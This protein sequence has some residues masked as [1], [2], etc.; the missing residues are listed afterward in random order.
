[1]NELG[2]R[3][4]LRKELYAPYYV[5][6]FAIH[7]FN[8]MNQKKKIYWEGGEVPSLRLHIIFVAPPGYMKSYYLKQM[9]GGDHAL[10]RTYVED[11]NENGINMIY[12]QNLNESGLVGTWMK[13]GEHMV[14]KHGLAERHA[15]SFVLVDEFKGITD[16]LRSNGQMDTQ[17]LAAL[18][19]GHIAK[20]MAG[21]TI[22]YDTNFTMWGGVQP[23]RYELEGGMG[24][25]MLFLVNN[26]DDKLKRELRRAQFEAKN[27]RSDDLG[28]KLFHREIDKW[29]ES[30]EII[31]SVEFDESIIDLYDKYDVEPYDTSYFDR[32]ILGYHLATMGPERQML[33]DVKDSYLRELIDREV[34]WRKQ[35][36]MGPDLIQIQ[37]VI[38]TF[39]VQ[40]GNVCAIKRQTYIEQCA[41]ISISATKALS[42]LE[43]LQHYGLVIVSGQNITMEI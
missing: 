32:L 18:D 15:E 9:G 22:S 39:G 38:K 34:E 4:V 7:C 11:E 23:G 8:L 20:D 2:R 1:M 19:H 35:V 25:R 3:K 28:S 13:E 36:S 37:N 30:L 41:S 29:R 42:R 5:C 27:I 6:S 17:L 26:P 43:E 21:G 16:A 10:L 33:L 24:R 14:R 40:A 31:E 12:A